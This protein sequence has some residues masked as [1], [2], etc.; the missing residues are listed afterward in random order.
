MATW[1]K[2]ADRQR[3]G[4]LRWSGLCRTSDH[5]GLRKNLSKGNQFPL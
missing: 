4:F 1:E 2:D 5:T 3:V